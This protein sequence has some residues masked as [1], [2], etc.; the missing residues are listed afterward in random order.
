MATDTDR[1]EP[2]SSEQFSS[3][4]VGQRIIFRKTRSNSKTWRAATIEETG[5][6]LDECEHYIVADDKR[7][8]ND[9]SHEIFDNT[10][11]LVYNFATGIFTKASR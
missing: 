9:S 6:D 5:F 4:T 8:P 1:V 7:V 10:K 3:L 11:P 2:V